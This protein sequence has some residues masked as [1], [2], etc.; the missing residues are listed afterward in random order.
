MPKTLKKLENL[1]LQKNKDI[2]FVSDAEFS[3]HELISHLLNQTGP[4]AVRISSFSISEMA[5]RSFFNLQESGQITS[6]SCLFDFNV[7]RHKLGLLFFASNVV[8]CIRLTKVHA[9]LIFIDNEDWNL[10]VVTSANLN[11]NDKKEV[12]IIINSRDHYSFYSEKYNQWFEEA[13]NISP[14]EFN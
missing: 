3:T 1:K 14:D 12:G 6:L 13:L 4:S 5:I 10:V 7:K 2:P 9:K 8:S 11:I